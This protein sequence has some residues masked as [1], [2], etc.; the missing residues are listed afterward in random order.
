M[1]KTKS[2]KR[3]FEVW[4]AIYRLSVVV[5]WETSK[6][7]LLQFA[8]RRGVT[9]TEEIWGKKF[10]RLS[11]NTKCNGFC[12]YF[13]DDNQDILV[14]LRKRPQTVVECGVLYH[15]LYHAVDKIIE[16]R[17]L[18]HEAESPA[19]IYE[20]LATQCNIFFWNLIENKK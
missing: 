19:Y 14:W 2:V 4:L 1:T 16:S 3:F 17:N 9:A 20:Y 18:Y 15:E 12:T 11:S 6:K 8:K 5:S 7:D 10:D 13:G